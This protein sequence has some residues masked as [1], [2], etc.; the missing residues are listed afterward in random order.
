MIQFMNKIYQ[1]KKGIIK[2]A[3]IN[4]SFKRLYGKSGEIT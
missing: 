2:D 1:S 4:N 3:N